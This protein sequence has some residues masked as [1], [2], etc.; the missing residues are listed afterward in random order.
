MDVEEFESDLG[1]V[2]VTK[3]HIER[4]KNENSED[5]ERIEKHFSDR[6]LTDYAHFEEIEDLKFEEGS[7]YPNIR[8]KVD[9]VWKRMF[10]HVGDEAR[11]C[12]NELEYRIKAYRQVFQ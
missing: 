4:E 6:K 1:K 5:W 11:E 10:F 9:G 12:F 8:L 7:I 3:S 2:A